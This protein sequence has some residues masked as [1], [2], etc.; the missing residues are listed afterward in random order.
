MYTF[1][2]ICLFFDFN[3]TATHLHFLRKNKLSVVKYPRQFK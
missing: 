2:A 1:G 3:F